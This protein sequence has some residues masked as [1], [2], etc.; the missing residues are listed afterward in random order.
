MKQLVIMPGGFH[1]FH[2]G[3]MSLYNAARQEFPDADV[4]VAAT[5]DTSSRPFPF[6]VKEKL[7]K[8]AG[9]APGR[10]VQVKS[11]FRALEITSGY[12]PNNTQLI[13][14]RSTKD[15]DKQPKP[16]GFKKD[17]TPSYLQPLSA[18]GQDPKP[19]SQQGYM[20]YLPTVEFASGLTSASEIRGSW[21]HL[22]KAAKEKLVHSIY[23]RTT[24]NKNLTNTVIGMLD[25]AI[26]T[27]SKE[28]DESF[29]D[30]PEAEE[31]FQRALQHLK[32]RAKQGRLVTRWNPEKR[33][34]YNVPVSQL[35]PSDPDYEEEKKT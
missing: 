7:A 14:V 15:R 2:A 23:P 12:D 33:Y 16:G 30:D 26:G 8:L 1:P 29:Y 4:Y 3:H 18:A 35:P 31:R 27:E 21:P 24:G 20:A 10:F 34:Y 5:D 17:G 9:V 19:M 25:L 11:P 6:A 32:M 22:G 13:F 28:V